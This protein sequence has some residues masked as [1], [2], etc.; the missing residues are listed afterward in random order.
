MKSKR[1]PQGSVSAYRV[2]ATDTEQA[3]ALAKYLSK[4]GVKSIAVID[5]ATQYGKGLADQFEKAMKDAG[6]SVLA[7]SGE[8]QNRRFQ[9][10]ANQS[11][12]LK[13]RLYFLGRD[14]R[15][16]C[17]LGQTDEGIGHAQPIGFSRWR[18]YGQIH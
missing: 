7:R 15:Y 17:D 1:T 18:V 4:Q 14:G 13:P 10:T 9:S 3:P 5:D 11:Q 8:R 2:V 12:S 6:V 16:R